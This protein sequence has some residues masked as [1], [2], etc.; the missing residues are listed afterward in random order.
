MKKW[1]K[2]NVSKEVV[3][4]LHKRFGVDALTASIF[5]RRGI[6]GGEDLMY[7]MEE[8]PRF[9]H[10]PFL[11]AVMEDAVNRIRDA[12]DEGEKV[13][14]FGDRDVDG[15]TSTAVLYDYLSSMGID[16]K[17]RLPT[18]DDTYGLSR[19]AIDDFSAEYGSLIITVDCGISN[20]EEVSYA[21]QKGID[22]IIT[23]HHN[24][25]ENLPSPAIIL[26]PK[27]PESGYPF[28]DISGCAVAYK[29]VGALK[30]S[31]DSLY[32]QE[33]CLMN[34]RPLNDA[35]A[36]ECLKLR[37]LVPAGHLEEIIVPGTVSISQTRLISF[38]SGQQIFVWDAPVIKKQL[39]HAFG[40]GVEFNM[41]DIRPE[42][43]KIIPGVQ[44]LSLLAIKDMSR[45]VR[46]EDKPAGEL[47]GFY[48]IFV[49]FILKQ[50]KKQTDTSLNIQLVMLAALADIMPLRNENRILVRRGL[51]LLNKGIVRQGLK[52]LLSRLSLLGK[53]ISST[54][55]SWSV[56]PVLNA[57]GR[58][59]QPE[60]S[61]KL[62]L[63]DD[64]A[65]RDRLAA[66]IIELNTQRRQLVSEAWVLTQKQAA[67]SFK[68][69]DEKLVIAIDEHI[70]RGISGIL[71][72]RLVQ[73]FEVPAIAVTFIDNGIAVGSMRSCRDY[74]ITVF[75]DQF[76]DLF[77]NHGGH[78]FAAGFSFKKERL[79][80]FLDRI[81]QL[82]PTIELGDEGNLSW[83]IDAEIPHNY[84]TPD[85][86]KLVDRFEPFGEANPPLL[87]M[88]KSLK[89][90][91]AQILGK[92]ERQ[93]LKLT[94]DCGKNKW[95]AMFW[96]EGERFH[97]DFD[98]GDSL[99]I[100]YQVT[101]NTFNGM[102]TP[103]LIITDIKKTT[104]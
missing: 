90:T 39:L 51:D 49:T 80:E 72:S 67:Q 17:W 41:M 58:L 3:S 19:Q 91:D 7:Y 70:N 62:F 61:L 48:N 25:P 57:A 14:I 4:E 87:F 35:Y 92:T 78:N 53:R 66:Q 15:I 11:F 55:L 89:V 75:L 36:I 10:S 65:E 16:V 28:K 104:S 40:D 5:S 46:Y 100:L 102:E 71:A 81:E 31:T 101:R 43:A 37:N 79:P 30:F 21:A 56:I 34:V 42:I 32:G 18:G 22:V 1:V 68:K 9:L 54:D 20:N 13:L 98:T 77:L 52:E 95:P 6:T 38:L 2:K 88:S 27:L 99:D 50:Q 93:H 23:D 45:I 26:D 74:D 60:L 96:G 97:R 64:P 33:I 44:S 94:L 86:L 8:D 103:Q 76:G 29:L 24:P 85:L 63:S 82:A 69:Y 59:G 84:L 47:D 73:Q 83:N 12:K